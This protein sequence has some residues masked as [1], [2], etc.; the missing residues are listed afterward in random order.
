[1]K[2]TTHLHLVP[3]EWSYTSILPNI[4]LHGLHYHYL[5]FIAL[6][7]AQSGAQWQGDVWAENRSGFEVGLHPHR[8]CG[9]SEE[10]HYVREGQYTGRYLNHRSAD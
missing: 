10:H 3:N 8:F 7:E 2:L 4:C 9:G 5:L 1:M 6:S